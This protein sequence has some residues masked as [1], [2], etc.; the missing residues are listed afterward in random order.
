MKNNKNFIAKIVLLCALI[1]CAIGLV[2]CGSSSVPDKDNSSDVSTD[3]SAFFYVEE[4]SQITITGLKDESLTEIVI[5]DNV[6]AIGERAFDNCDSLT[7]VEISNSVTSIGDYAFVDCNSLTS[8]EI[9]DSVTSLGDYAF[10]GCWRLT[11][12]TVDIN[13][14]AYKSID[15]NLYSKDGKTL[16]QYAIGKTATSFTIPDS[17]TSIGSD[18]F[19]GCDSLTSV[20]IGDSVTSIGNGAFAYCDSLTSITVDINNTAYKSIDG[21]LYSKDGKTLIQYAIG[22]TATS[23]TIPDSVISIGEGAFQNCYSLT[24]VVI[25][26]SVISI[27]MGAFASCHSLTSVYYM[28]NEEGWAKISI[29]VGNSDLTSATRYYYSESEPT[30]SGNYWHYDEDG[31]PIPW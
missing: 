6:T 30:S 18:A 15:G 3:L 28:G 16:I 26:D 12:I 23:F 8:F 4:N 10:R 29:D 21:N 7:S 22:K 11:S 31:N 13:N 14:T 17:V 24:S 1:I 20:V 5:P 27:G 25:G 19:R 2:A 9:G